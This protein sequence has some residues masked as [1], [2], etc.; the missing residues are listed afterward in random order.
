MPDYTLLPVLCWT[1]ES[2]FLATTE[3]QTHHLALHERPLAGRDVRWLL[4][5]LYGEQSPGPCEPETPALPAEPR[6]L[7]TDNGMPTVLQRFMA[8]CHFAYLT[9]DAGMAVPYLHSLGIPPDSTDLC[10]DTALQEAVGKL[11]G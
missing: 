7:V 5:G 8:M 3:M 4:D 1:C 9:L 6:A 11:Q 10:W 2:V